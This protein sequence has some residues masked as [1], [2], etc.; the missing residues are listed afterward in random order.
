MDCIFCKIIAHEL[1]STVITENEDILVIKDI[2]PKAPIHYLIMPK[3]HIVDVLD[4]KKEDM[5]L[6]VKM[7]EMIQYVAKDRVKNHNFRLMVNNGAEVGQ[8]IFHLHYH[9]LAGTKMSHF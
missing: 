7:V 4:L 5:F 6:A 9:F 1:P 3:K 2:A 8:I